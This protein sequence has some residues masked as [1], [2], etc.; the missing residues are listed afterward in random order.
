VRFVSRSAAKLVQA[1]VQILLGDTLGELVTFYAAADL[2]F[3]GGSFVPI[4]GHNLLEP[5][6]LGLPVLSGPNNFNAPDI[7]ARL[8]ESGAAIELASALDLTNTLVALASDAEQR[9]RMGT[10]GIEVIEKNRGALDRVLAII[11]QRL[12]SHEINTAKSMRH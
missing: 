2:A 5:A 11:E 4:G 7:A 12:T 3:V 10:I 9:T 6:A 1:N 8:F